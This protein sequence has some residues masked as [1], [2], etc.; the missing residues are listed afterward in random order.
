M[1]IERSSNVVGNRP[2][3]A[4]AFGHHTECIL[5]SWRSPQRRTNAFDLYRPALRT[6]RNSAL[7]PLTK[8]VSASSIS[9]VGRYRSI[10]R[11]S[12]ATVILAVWR[13]R[14]T[15]PLRTSRV[16]VLPHR[17]SE[18]RMHRIGDTP[19]ASWTYVF[20]HHKAWASAATGGNTTN[21][22]RV[23]AMSSSSSRPSTVSFHGATAPGRIVVLKSAL[24]TEPKAVSASAA[25]ER[26]PAA[27][28]RR[29]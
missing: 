6:P 26:T 19:E 15:R 10:V 24:S 9:N 21:R 4:I 13:G 23:L 8:I 5:G 16:R 7:L 14:S 22:W 25:G 20:R 1:T 29:I 2:M 3:S 18:E 11:Y 17:F 28:S 12:A 27:R